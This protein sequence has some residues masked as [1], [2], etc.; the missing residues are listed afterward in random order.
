MAFGIAPGLEFHVVHAG[1]VSFYT[2]G[3]L[4]YAMSISSKGEDSTETSN[5]Q[6]AFS[7]NGIVGAE[8]YPWENVSFGAEYQ[9]GVRFSSTSSKAKGTST[10]GPSATDIGIAGPIRISLGIGF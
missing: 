2:G 1:P 10:D 7:V 3:V 8:F 4:S 5:S 6:S 9:A